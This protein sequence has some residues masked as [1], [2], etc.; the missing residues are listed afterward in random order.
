MHITCLSPSGCA[1]V[2]VGQ[3][4][5]RKRLLWKFS[6]NW[7]LKRSSFFN[8]VATTARWQLI[9]L[10]LLPWH[11]CQ[12]LYMLIYVNSISDASFKCYARGVLCL[13]FFFLSRIIEAGALFWRCKLLI[14]SLTHKHLP[15]HIR[16]ISNE[17]HS[18]CF[19]LCFPL[20]SLSLN[21]SFTQRIIAQFAFIKC[22][23]SSSFRF[24]FK[25]WENI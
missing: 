8:H 12:L 18:L 2:C 20:K 7:S 9:C 15:T 23:L 24:L 10:R 21:Y 17:S 19:F 6:D 4:Q 1:S 14:S 11:L 3:Q 25:E 22:V 13:F 16:Y 5:W